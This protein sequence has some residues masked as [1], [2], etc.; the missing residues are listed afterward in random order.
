[1]IWFFLM[2]M[3]AGGVGV[4]MILKWWFRVHL[5]RV[6]A[7]EMLEDLRKARESGNAD[8]YMSKGKDEQ[9]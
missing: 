8:I 4:L 6:S 9:Q 7:E 1:M 3:I 5:K 2:G